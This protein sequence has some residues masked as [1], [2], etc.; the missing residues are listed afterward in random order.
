MR[1]WRY[2]LQFHGKLEWHLSVPWDSFGDDGAN[3][4]VD[5]GDED[6]AGQNGGETEDQ[7]EESEGHHQEHHDGANDIEPAGS[8]S[9][10][11]SELLSDSTSASSFSHS[12]MDSEGSASEEAPTVHD[13]L[14]DVGYSDPSDS[15]EV[16][17]PDLSTGRAFMR[18]LSATHLLELRDLWNCVYDM[19]ALDICPSIETMKEVGVFS[20]ELFLICSI[21]SHNIPPFRSLTFHDFM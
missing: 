17:G 9:S 21:K 1:W 6:E 11:A 3:S 12:S 16:D 18:M 10:L 20:L 4:N 15:F 2:S 13:D 8:F 7:E 14:F 5:G 19:V